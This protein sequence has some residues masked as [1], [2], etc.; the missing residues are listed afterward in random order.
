VY[1]IKQGRVG[2]C[3]TLATEVRN[4]HWC[5]TGFMPGFERLAE[6]QLARER[7]F[8]ERALKRWNGQAGGR[9]ERSLPA[10]TK[11]SNGKAPSFRSAP[12]LA[13]AELRPAHTQKEL[14][15]SYITSALVCDRNPKLIAA[16]LGHASSH[17][18]V[19]NYG[20]FLDPEN[21]PDGAETR[22]LRR[23]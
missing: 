8:L 2:E 21:W 16:E 1:G 6:G 5:K 12:D 19:N 7:S 3:E 14:R 23:S 13:R 18:V 22:R 11:K 17:M 20:S 9:Q 4:E 15:R 10:R